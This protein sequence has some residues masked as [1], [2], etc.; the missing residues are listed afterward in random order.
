MDYQ[1]HI[2]HRKFCTEKIKR[3]LV[4]FETT[5]HWLEWILDCPTGSR[6]VFPW[7]NDP[8]HKTLMAVSI[9]HFTMRQKRLHYSY[10]PNVRSSARIRFTNEIME[11]RHPD[12]WESELFAHYKRL[13]MIFAHTSPGRG[14]VSAPVGDVIERNVWSQLALWL[15][16]GTGGR[17]K[18]SLIHDVSRYSPERSA[19]AV[20][21]YCATSYQSSGVDNRSSEGRGEN[22]IGRVYS[23]YHFQSLYDTTDASILIKTTGDLQEPANTWTSDT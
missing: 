18:N 12:S 11:C 6:Y 13:L 10:R 19:V 9:F 15:K 23:R 4:E 7:N 17:R 22:E 3:P 14:V 16:R 1:S 5:T 21:R 8:T 20:D 2:I